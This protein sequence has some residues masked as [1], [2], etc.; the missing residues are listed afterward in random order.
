MDT[1]TNHRQSRQFQDPNYNYKKE[2][3]THGD[4]GFCDEN[5]NIEALKL[6]K[7]Y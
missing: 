5:L 2:F 7:D 1:T 4:W 3:K 6:H